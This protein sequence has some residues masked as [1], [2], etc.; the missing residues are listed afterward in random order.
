M[1]AIPQA[2]SLVSQSR[3]DIVPF[4]DASGSIDPA[5]GVSA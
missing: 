1:A 2:Q 5:P 3:R 4:E